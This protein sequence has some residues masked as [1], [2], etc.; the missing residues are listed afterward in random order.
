MKSIKK[1]MFVCAAASILLCT[2]AS[3]V[4]VPTWRGNEGSTWQQW[5]FSS[6]STSPSPDAGHN[7]YGD[8]IMTI[9]PIGSWI[10]PPGAWP[11]SGEIDIFIPN[12]PETAERKEIWL[13]L[14]WQAGSNQTPT[15]PDEPWVAVTP[16][17][18][19]QMSRKDTV[20]NGWTQSL[21]E[22]AICPNPPYE[23]ITVKGDIIVDQLMVDTICIP[24]PATIFLLGMG[25][26]ITVRRTRKRRS[27]CKSNI[28]K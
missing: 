20:L 13:Q 26:L 19:M 4:V 27:F 5:D 25:G 24:E 8:P 2:T 11:L 28:V 14:T 16:F 23:W 15:L 22:I 10:D 7:P 1:I 6:N 21:F 12:R 17:S 9:N 3:A 18:S